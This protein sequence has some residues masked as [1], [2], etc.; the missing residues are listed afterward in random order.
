[1]PE[2]RVIVV[3]IK[4]R[5]R[6]MGCNDLTVGDGIAQ[7]P[8][9]GLASKLKNPARHRQG[10][11]RDGELSHERVEPFP[12][13]YACDRPVAAA[14]RNTSFSYSRSRIR[15]RASRSSAASVRVRPGL[16]PSSTA[17]RC[18]QVCS[19]IR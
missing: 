14:R 19:I 8:V 9:V 7:P 3:G 16:A 5:V 12:G 18:N 6:A 1:M 17:A 4:Q 11:T 13:R 2:L 15:L 10:N